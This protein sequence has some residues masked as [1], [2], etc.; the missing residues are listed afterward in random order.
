MAKEKKSRAAVGTIRMRASAGATVIGLPID[1]D[2]AVLNITIDEDGTFEVDESL[3]ASDPTIIPRLIAA[4]CTQVFP[5]T[6]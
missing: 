4:G 1:G 6:D 2:V 5:V 3:I